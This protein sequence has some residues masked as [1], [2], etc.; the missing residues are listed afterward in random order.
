MPDDAPLEYFSTWLAQHRRGELDAEVAIAL[1][2]VT[3]ACQELGKN[4][5][6]TIVIKVKPPKPG[7]RTILLVDEVKVSCPQSSREDALYY[8]AEG[9][10]LQREDPTQARFFDEPVRRADPDTDEARKVGGDQ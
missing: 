9:G 3:A 2:E 10:R 6:V 5:S 1:A 4:G 7:A 8:V